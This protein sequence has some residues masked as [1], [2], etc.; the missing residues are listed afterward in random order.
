MRPRSA[1]RA[2]RGGGVAGESGDDDS[3]GV[4]RVLRFRRGP[5][6]TIGR[7]FP[8]F[9]QVSL[10]PGTPFPLPPGEAQPLPFTLKPPIPTIYGAQVGLRLPLTYEWNLTVERRLGENR[11]VTM[12][13]IG[14]AGRQLLRQSYYQS[15]TADISEAFLLT[16]AA[17]SDFHSYQAQFQ[18]RLA[19]GLLALVSYTLGKSLDNESSESDLLLKARQLNPKT[20]RGR[21]IS[22]SGRRSPIRCRSSD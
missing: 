20:D 21:R 22:T 14:A 15:P 19:H 9:R 5:G 16:N 11:E 7:G 8:Y 10:R 6:G 3:G 1:S 17:F 4:G 13:Y 18:Q 12:A 2:A